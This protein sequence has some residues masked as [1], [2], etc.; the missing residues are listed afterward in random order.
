MG[1]AFLYVCVCVYLILLTFFDNEFVRAK[2]LGTHNV[3]KPLQEE[4]C[5]ACVCVCVCIYTATAATGRSQCVCEWFSSSSSST[6][7][8]DARVC[9][10][11]CVL[12]L[13][14]TDDFIKQRD[15]PHDIAIDG[16]NDIVPQ[17][18]CH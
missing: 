17:P 6:T 2:D 8:S 14:K 15:A 5:G 12:L 16:R 10:C 13:E 9:M 7:T 18:G 1:G 3:D 11:V 4:L